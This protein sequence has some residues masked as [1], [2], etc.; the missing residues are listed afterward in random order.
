MLSNDHAGD[1]AVITPAA[2]NATINFFTTLSRPYIDELAVVSPQKPLRLNRQR[3]SLKSDW[4]DRGR[5]VKATCAVRSLSEKLLQ[6]GYKNDGYCGL[7]QEIKFT[8]AQR[9]AVTAVFQR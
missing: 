7:C 3:D 8:S 4:M 9:N 6:K 2:T 1:E 5:F